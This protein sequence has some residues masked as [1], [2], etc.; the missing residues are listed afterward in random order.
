MV[1]LLGFQSSSTALTGEPGSDAENAQGALHIA[2]NTQSSGLSREL[3]DLYY[4]KLQGIKL[5]AKE[6][7]LAA[8]SLTHTGFAIL[9]KT[10]HW[11][12]D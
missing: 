1:R 3:L 5:K 11:H 10:F 9:V 8:L 12:N 7:I 2:I 4:V 6:V